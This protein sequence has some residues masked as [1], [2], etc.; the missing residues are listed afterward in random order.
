MQICASGYKNRGKIGT[1]QC[2]SRLFYR[3]I[4]KIPVFL[5]FFVIFRRG[6]LRGFKKGFVFRKAMRGDFLRD[7]IKS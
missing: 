5:G 4:G 7:K 6:C 1:F 2:F 3:K